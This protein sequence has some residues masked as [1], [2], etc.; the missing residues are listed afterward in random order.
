MANTA[1]RTWS[2]PAA[3]KSPVSRPSQAAQVTFPPSIGIDLLTGEMLVDGLGN[4]VEVDGDE[5]WRQWCVMTANTQQNS[6]PIFSRRFGPDTRG[7]MAQPDPEMQ[8][9]AFQATLK[10]ALLSDPR[11]REVRI[12]VVDLQDDL[13]TV[14]VTCISR[15]GLATTFSVG[16]TTGG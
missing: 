7:S 11:T 4:P 13:A 12:E 5:A 14:S 10:R 9:A 3:I 1:Y 8:V 6:R 16:V 2:V 15:R